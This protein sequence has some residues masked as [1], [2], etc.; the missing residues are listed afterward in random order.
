[1]LTQPQ[2]SNVIPDGKAKSEPGSKPARFGLRSRMLALAILPIMLSGFAILISVVQNVGTITTALYGRQTNRTV[3][4]LMGNIDFTKPKEIER[5]FKQAMASSDILGMNLTQIDTNG[6]E[7]SQMVFRNE[8]AK[9]EFESL[10]P[11]YLISKNKGL[12][13]EREFLKSYNYRAAELGIYVVRGSGLGGSNG[14]TQTRM[15]DIM[16]QTKLPVPSASGGAS[17]FRIIQFESAK[18]IDG[19]LWAVGWNIIW[20][21]VGA[22]LVAAL[23]GVMVAQSVV[24]PVVKLTEL[25]DAMSIGDLETPIE[26]KSR[27]ELGKL[28]DALERTRLSLRLAIERTQRKRAERAQQ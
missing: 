8:Q 15:I 12:E 7:R 6:Q 20:F 17:G 26:V 27:D 16:D 18:R 2:I 25:A 1:M 10:E 13:A 3:Q 21:M 9:A 14:A 4:T 5:E 19:E 24:R 23:A 28:G 11:N 22:V